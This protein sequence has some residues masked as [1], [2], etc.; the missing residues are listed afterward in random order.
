MQALAALFLMNNA[1]YQLKSITS[2]RLQNYV[3]KGFQDDCETK[4]SLSCQGNHEMTVESV[5]PL[6]SLL[7]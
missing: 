2:T 7:W 3:S 5:V 6:S 4:A 1:H